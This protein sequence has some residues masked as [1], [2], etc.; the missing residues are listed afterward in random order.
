MNVG[1]AL[2]YVPTGL[3]GIGTR[4]EIEIRDQAVPAEVVAVPFVP[5]HV[6]KN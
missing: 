2:C 4:L 1:V 5:S 6:K 3:A